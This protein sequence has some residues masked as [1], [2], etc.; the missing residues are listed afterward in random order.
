MKF[1]KFMHSCIL[2]FVFICQ[3]KEY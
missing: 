3:R 1:G 2:V